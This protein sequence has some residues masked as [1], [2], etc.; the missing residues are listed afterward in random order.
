MILLIFIGLWTLRLGLFLFYR[1]IKDGKDK[2]FDELKTNFLKFMTVWTMSGAWV[3]I[4][5]SPA[6]AA[7]C[8]NK[9]NDNLIFIIVGSFLW[10]SGF[11]IEVISDRQ[12]RKFKKKNND[13]YITSGLWAYSRHP[14]YVGE[15]MLWTGITIISFPT[16]AGLQLITLVSP[17]FVYLLLTKVSGLNILEENADKKWGNEKAYNEYKKNTPIL[18]PFKK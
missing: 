13:G 12:K 1:V 6:I 9:I 7:L 16:L 17:L 5:A 11:I 10:I 15:I 4:T 2:R 8:S 18:F 14:N 3:F